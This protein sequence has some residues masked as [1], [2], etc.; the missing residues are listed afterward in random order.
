M[1][2]RVVIVILFTLLSGCELFTTRTPEDPAGSSGTY[3]QP[4]S[5]LI[6]ISNFQNAVTEKNTENFISCLSDSAKFGVKN[7]KFDPSS[8]IGARFNE[9]FNTWSILSERQSF[10]SM[11][12]KVTTDDKPSLQL[13]NARFD[14]R[15][16][17]SAV[18]VAE[19]IIKV[20]HSSPTIPKLA[21]GTLR[22]TIVPNQLNQWSI[23][24]WTDLKSTAND[25]IPSTWSELKV[26]FSN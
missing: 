10:Y 16:P 22:L 25:T 14:V 6:V 26:L 19:Y 11:M 21:A 23:S 12:S 15:V 18:Y 3:Q 7:F 5:E 8:E 13:S 17:D 24:R 20:N 1:I 4:T 9:Q 2:T